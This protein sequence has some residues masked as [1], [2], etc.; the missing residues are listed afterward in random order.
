MR[1]HLRSRRLMALSAGTVVV[2]AL[3][4]SPAP[5]EQPRPPRGFRRG[6]HGW[7]HCRSSDLD[8]YV[9]ERGNDLGGAATE[10]SRVGAFTTPPYA[11][12]AEPASTVAASVTSGAEAGEICGKNRG[13]D[14]RRK[15]EGSA[16]I[17]RFSASMARGREGREPWGR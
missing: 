3:A 4:T 8:G 2:I 10:I 17:R 11:Y 15:F 14:G 16:V 1:T 6:H 12:S 7:W 9:V 13:A 5:Q